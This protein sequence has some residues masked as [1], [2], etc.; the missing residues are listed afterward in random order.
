MGI[1]DAGSGTDEDYDERPQ[2]VPKG[3]RTGKGEKGKGTAA[4]SKSLRE[5]GLEMRHT[6]TAER[7]KIVRDINSDVSLLSADSKAM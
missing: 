7:R 1:N 6:I 4:R 3:K 2:H 5:G